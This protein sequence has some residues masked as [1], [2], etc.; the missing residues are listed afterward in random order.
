MKR[1][2]FIFRSAERRLFEVTPPTLPPEVQIR[3][4]VCIIYVLV[5]YI[6]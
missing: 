2:P 3:N 5:I 6:V 4:N 1:N